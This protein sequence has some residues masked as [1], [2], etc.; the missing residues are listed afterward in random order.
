MCVFHLDS[1]NHS[2]V[3][4]DSKS[5]M[6]ARCLA[7]F[8]TSKSKKKMIESSSKNADIPFLIIEVPVSFK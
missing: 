1:G 3:Y 6:A 7:Y 8:L 2:S 5:I 4:A